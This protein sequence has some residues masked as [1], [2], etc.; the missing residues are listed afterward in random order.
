[1]AAKQPENKKIDKRLMWIME[2]Q[3]RQDA[4]RSKGLIKGVISKQL[5][6]QDGQHCW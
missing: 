4:Q 5:V 1:M 3:E 6:G 2:E